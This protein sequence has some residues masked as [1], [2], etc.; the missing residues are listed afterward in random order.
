MDIDKINRCFLLFV[1]DYSDEFSRDIRG[2]TE[3]FQQQ[4]G[5]ELITRELV[6]RESIALFQMNLIGEDKL[7]RYHFK[8]QFYQ[9]F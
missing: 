2:N 4:Y 7:N 6:I 1:I 5:I 8:K 3:Y 9:R